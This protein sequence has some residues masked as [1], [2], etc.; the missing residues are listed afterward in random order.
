[1]VRINYYYWTNIF[2]FISLLSLSS[3]IDFESEQSDFCLTN[4]DV[5]PFLCEKKMDKSKAS[6]IDIE[7]AGVPHKKAELIWQY[8]QQYPKSNFINLLEIKGVG[9]KT[10]EK[11]EK[12]FIDQSLP[13]PAKSSAA[14]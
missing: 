2:G 14:E 5:H 6:I 13:N 12:Y 3:F 9:K 1:M 10:V 4:A 7:S 8:W 11:L